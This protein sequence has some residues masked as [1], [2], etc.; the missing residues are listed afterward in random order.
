MVLMILIN[1]VQYANFKINN[2]YLTYFSEYD[3]SSYLYYVHCVYIYI[4]MCVCVYIYI[5][6]PSLLCQLYEP[7]YKN[8][9]NLIHNMFL[10]FMVC[11]HMSL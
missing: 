6:K 3:D 5:C 9:I 1:S 11:A 10:L 8:S 4:Y 7:P 2:T